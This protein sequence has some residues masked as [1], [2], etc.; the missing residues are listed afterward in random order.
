MILFSK[1]IQ[2]FIHCAHP[3]PTLQLALLFINSTP[4]STFS[5]SGEKNSSFKKGLCWENPYIYLCIFLG[6]YVKLS[7][8]SSA[9][10]LFIV[11]LHP[12]PRFQNNSFTK[13]ALEL[14]MFPINPSIIYNSPSLNDE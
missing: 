1:S 8:S 11:S 12:T 6:F 5:P 3:L 7:I 4:L 2:S 10:T 13:S 9:S 14:A